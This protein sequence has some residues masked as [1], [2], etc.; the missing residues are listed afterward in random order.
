MMKTTTAFGK[1]SAMTL[2]NPP[3]ISTLTSST[4]KRTSNDYY[5]S[6][7]MISSCLLSSRF[8]IN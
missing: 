5:L 8:L 7:S 3:H 4:D 1:T 6:V 2:G